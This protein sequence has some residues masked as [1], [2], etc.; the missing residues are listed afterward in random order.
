MKGKEQQQQ[1]KKKEHQK[2]SVKHWQPNQ[3]HVD[4]ARKTKQKMS[5]QIIS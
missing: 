5:E 1:Q 2:H 3:A 4:R